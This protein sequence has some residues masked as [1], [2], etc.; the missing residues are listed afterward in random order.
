MWWAH[1]VSMQMACDLQHACIQPY[2]YYYRQSSH[3][4]NRTNENVID[5]YTMRF[6]FSSIFYAA[7]FVFQ[8]KIQT[9]SRFG[10]TNGLGESMEVFA[11]VWWYQFVM[12]AQSVRFWNS[13]GNHSIMTLVIFSFTNSFFRTADFSNRIY[14]PVFKGE[15]AIH[16]SQHSN[17]SCV[18]HKFY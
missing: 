10:A 7:K 17:T 4:E 2:Q 3:F 5:S 13:F 8:P 18:Q 11:C 16:I 6:H 9:E 1:N 15:S 12:M 14:L